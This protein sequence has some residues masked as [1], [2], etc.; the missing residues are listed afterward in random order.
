MLIDAY[1]TL[2]QAQNPQYEY[3]RDDRNGA[4][5]VRLWKRLLGQDSRS[6]VAFVKSDLLF[7]ARSWTHPGSVRLTLVDAVEGAQ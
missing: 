1:L 6:V 7:A 3:G 5:Y 4:K 2:L